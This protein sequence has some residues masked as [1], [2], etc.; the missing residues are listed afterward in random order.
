MLLNPQLPPPTAPLVP[1]LNTAT[2]PA[3]PATS[4]GTTFCNPV[5]TTVLQEVPNQ[6]TSTNPTIS[7]TIKTELD[8]SPP[9][10]KS[11]PD[12]IKAH[13][14]I[15]TAVAVSV[16][17]TA[18]SVPVTTPF[19]ARSIHNSHIRFMHHNQNTD[20]GFAISAIHVNQSKTMQLQMTG[21][22]GGGGGY[23]Y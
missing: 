2:P 12:L 8:N 1:P 6:P 13:P 21:G 4:A 11:I 3:T 17:G 7:Q 10:K 18:V 5:N 23:M 16:I 9:E 15:S 22:G 20:L 19:I 14:Y